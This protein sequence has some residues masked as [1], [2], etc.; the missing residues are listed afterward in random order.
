MKLTKALIEQAKEIMSDNKVDKVYLNDK[1]EFF[2]VHNY[3]M[4]SVH[5]DKSKLAEITADTVA[6]AAGDSTESIYAGK[7][8]TDLKKLA[9]E[10]A[11]AFD[12]KVT[13]AALI[14]E[15]EA[16]DKKQASAPVKP[17]E[18][19]SLEELQNA[20]KEKQIE[21][22]EDATAEQLIELLN[23]PPAE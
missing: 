7:S 21:F 8:L 9:K 12:N 17:F 19:M 16:W 2:T 22:E 1:G 11:I 15:L 23:E 5:N 14:Q 10:R 4:I 13:K 18:E 20:A 6:P 3:A